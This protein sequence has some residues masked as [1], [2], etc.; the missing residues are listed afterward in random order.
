MLFVCGK[1][2][3]SFKKSYTVLFCAL[4]F[5]NLVVSKIYNKKVNVFCKSLRLNI[6]NFLYCYSC[7]CNAE[8]LCRKVGFVFTECEYGQLEV[9][10]VGTS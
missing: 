8:F 10:C 3:T 7:F 2:V 4:N 1:R 5:V 6:L 9:N